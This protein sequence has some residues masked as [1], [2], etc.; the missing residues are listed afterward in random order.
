M[1]KS[2]FQSGE[3]RAQAELGR[4]WSE[5]TKPR[6]WRDPNVKI[7]KAEFWRGESCGEKSLKITGDSPG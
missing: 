4:L 2:V 1:K 5:E 3:G 7:S 6:V